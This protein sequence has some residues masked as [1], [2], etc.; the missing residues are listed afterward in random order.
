MDRVVASFVLTYDDLFDSKRTL[1]RQLQKTLAPQ[2]SEIL[3]DD[4]GIARAQGSAKLEMD[5]I[6]NHSAK[7]NRGTAITIGVL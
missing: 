3:V 5:N 1:R 6:Q 7:S 4:R 2:K